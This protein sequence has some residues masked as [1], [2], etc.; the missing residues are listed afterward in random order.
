MDPLQKI[1]DYSFQELKDVIE[2]DAKCMDMLAQR[3]AVRFIML[4]NFDT[5]KEL[6]TFFS[7]IGVK[8]L[9]IESMLEG[10]KDSWI[11][12]DDIKKVILDT[13]ES[14][15]VTPFSELVRFYDDNDFN[16][17]IEEIS[18]SEDI[19]HPS[20]RIYI[21]LIGLQNRMIGFLQHFSRI[22]ESAPIWRC[23]TQQQESKV[24]VTD[25]TDTVENSN[26]CVLKTFYDWLKFWK[27]A[28]PQ[29]KV[30]C[31]A[32][33]I[34]AF[35]KRSQPDNIFSFIELENSY[36]FLSQL[37]GLSFPFDYD[38]NDE[39]KWEELLKEL[40]GQEPSSFSFSSYVAHRF[41]MMTIDS[42]NLLRIWA[43]EKTSTFERW[44]L[45]QTILTDKRFENQQY[46]RSCLNSANIEETP[47][48]L[49]T[50]IAENVTF[51][52]ESLPSQKTM[53]ERFNLMASS[54]DL[55]N[56]FVPLNTQENLKDVIV[57]LFK[58]GNVKIAKGL[59]THT[60]Q[61]EKVL[62]VGWYANQSNDGFPYDELKKMY[63]TMA[64]YLKTESSQVPDGQD[65]VHDYFKHYRRAKI[66]DKLLPEI[67]KY[68]GEHN[69]SSEQFYAWYH[70]FENSHHA[71]AKSKVKEVYWIDALGAEFIPYLQWLIE[72]R[73]L[74]IKQCTYTRAD[75]PTSTAH[76]RFEVPTDHIFRQL[77]EKA[78]DKHGYK[79][80]E[81]LI[82]ELDC[83]KEIVDRII[84]NHSGKN[85][86][87]AIVSDHGLSCL[88]RKVDSLK[89][90]KKAEHEGRYFEVGDSHLKQDSD[91]VVH[92]N[93]SDGK[94]YK[95][96]LKHNSLGH[97]PTHE[98]H[99]GCCPEEVLVPLIIIS[100]SG[101][102]TQYNVTLQVNR[103]P[104]TKPV[105][106]VYI[107]PKPKS[108]SLFFSGKQYFLGFQ[109]GTL[110][111]VEIDNPS[112]GS[113]TIEV[114]PSEGQSYAFE[115]EFYGVG[116]SKNI[117]K[118]F[119]I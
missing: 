45:K 115:I 66:Y 98:V 87:I 88:S 16:G 81:T 50:A 108:A 57:D 95:V 15:F 82:D 52:A 70:S 19:A 61:F 54:K 116:F 18:L 68:I 89:Y 62:A 47:T 77:D 2:Q 1:L 84:Y 14:T 71:L 6:N 56:R 23:N 106:S 43:D 59:C 72:E 94:S 34:L 117:D 37:S 99:G 38:T 7:D 26:I 44:L 12:S 93:E 101:C 48:Q 29:K 96:A 5:L 80:Y 86:D 17:F 33:P 55:M 58:K 97:V 41:N 112:R 109:S 49:L 21:P 113:F 35:Y 28:A 103:I 46:L 9:R 114:V 22:Q 74:N 65:W 107:S 75:I 100:T 92:T 63:P 83:L 104:I 110:W 31:S 90:E 4:D 11:T 91:Y 25:K 105:L 8:M 10:D 79:K 78:H 76:N 39:S 20:K 30:V 3:Y 69:S 40:N 27:T 64:A 51:F 111:T 85:E 73:G 119:E 32:L 42:E 13:T 24:Y 102:S 67:T 53:E 36:Q 60:F 118:T